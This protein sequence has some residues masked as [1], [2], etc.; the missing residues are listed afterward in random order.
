MSKAS[1]CIRML[2]I[3]Y[4]RQV[5]GIAEL[6]S[7]LE[8]NPRNIPEYKKELES[9]GYYIE[10]VPGRYGG[11]RLNK[12][13]LFPSVRLTEEEQEGLM[14]G[15][16]YLFARN[17]FMQ[18]AEYAGAMA[19]ISAAAVRGEVPRDETVVIPRFPL[20]M[21]EQ[22]LQERYAAIA[23]CIAS[24]TVM[25]IDY[26]SNDN[27]VRT[28]SVHPYK[29]YM[30]NNGWFVLAFCETVKDLRYFK[31]N[32]IVRYREEP[33]KFRVLCS[34]KE[35][36]WLDEFGMRRNGEWY[37][38]KLKF[39]GKYAMIVQDYLYGKEQSVEC[40]DA[41]TTILTLKM[42]YRDNIVSFVLSHGD[43]CEVL[44]PEWL[45]EEVYEQCRKILRK[46]ENRKQYENYG[47]VV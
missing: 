40:I 34:Y 9:A 37:A 5:V 3:L 11:Y 27:I 6:A 44:E 45:K 16:D 7:L 25:T 15:Y 33:R 29:L 19:K 35:R 30:Y 32:R 31:L 20:A 8:T 47:G 36:E 22:D 43:R 28:R 42:Q 1:L 23:K 24:K 13:R 4:S 46:E 2:T 39:T 10:M 18:K 17:D 14:Q 38:V 26:R 12:D 41:D 21:P